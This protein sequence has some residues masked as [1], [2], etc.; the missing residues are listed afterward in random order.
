[1]AAVCGL[2]AAECGFHGHGSPLPLNIITSCSIMLLLCSCG[3]TTDRS[4]H[5]VH[6]F[7][8]GRKSDTEMHKV[9]I[10]MKDMSIYNICLY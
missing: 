1:M 3:R 4:M 7:L 9:H 8:Q 10:A 2:K 5:H 6:Q